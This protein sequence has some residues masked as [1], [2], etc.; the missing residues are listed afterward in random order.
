MVSFVVQNKNQSLVDLVNVVKNHPAINNIFFETWMNDK[1]SI[2]QIAIFA[3]NYWEWTYRFP[4]AIAQLIMNTPDTELRV[5]YSKILFSEMGDGNYKKSHVVLFENFIISLLN[6]LDGDVYSIDSLRS[7]FDLTN[8]TKLL[9]DGQSKLYSNSLQV[10]VGAQLAIEW[11]AYTM[12][13]KLYEGA[14]IYKSLW[15][16]LDGFHEDCEFFYTH[17]GATEKD[18]KVSSLLSATKFLT[19]KNSLDEIEYGFSEHLNLIEGF[20][21]GLSRAINTC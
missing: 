9:L 16:D 5:E 17:I 15:D 10:A 4:Q 12:I 6:N 14:R 13:S 18:H 7:T 19:R 11:Q 21:I 1:L 3:R 2:N 8:E 20:W